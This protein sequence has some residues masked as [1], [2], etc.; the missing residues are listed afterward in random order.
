MAL[1]TEKNSVKPMMN[2]TDVSFTLIMKLLPIC[3][4]MLRSAC[5][6]ITL[7]IV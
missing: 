1:W 6:R 4:M 5:G 2:M 7:V 3:G